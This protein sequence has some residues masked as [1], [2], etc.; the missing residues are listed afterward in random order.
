MEVA[1]P[2]GWNKNR[3]LVLDFYNQRRAQLKTVE[4]NPAHFAIAKLEEKFEVDVITQNVDDLH[5]RA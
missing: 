4:P 1:S 3:E 5:E 2:Q